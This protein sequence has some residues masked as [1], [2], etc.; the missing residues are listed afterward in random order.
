MIVFGRF[1]HLAAADHARFKTRH[2]FSLGECW[3]ATRVR[4]IIVTCLAIAVR[5]LLVTT[6]TVG[7]IAYLLLTNSHL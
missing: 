1:N 5:G 3:D 2:Y 6:I 4:G 7:I